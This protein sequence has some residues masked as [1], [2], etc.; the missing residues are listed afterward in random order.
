MKKVLTDLLAIVR[1]GHWS[2]ALSLLIIFG[3]GR[4]AFAG[5]P[6]SDAKASVELAIPGALRYLEKEALSW[7]AEM[8]CASCHHAPMMLWACETARAKGFPVKESAVAEIRAFI[9]DENNAA[10]LFPPADA[11]PDRDGTQIGSIYALLALNA[12][13]GGW[14]K[15]PLA[16]QTRAHFAGMQREDGSW[17]PFPSMGRPPILEQGGASAQLLVAAFAGLSADAVTPETVA[18]VEK[19]K[20]WLARPLENPSHQLEVTNYIAALATGASPEI[21][22]VRE[23]SLRAQQ[24]PD[25]SWAQSPDMAGDALATGQ[26]LYALGKAG[27]RLD[28]PAVARAVTF[29]AASQQPDGSWPMVS[30]PVVGGPAAGSLEPSENRVPIT[31]MGA[32]WAV[33]GLL[34]VL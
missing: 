15:S 13:P 24:R 20:V 4:A 34:A 29:L 25:G 23:A 33:L 7:K 6:A 8:G 18:T 28:D 27:K 19:A 3:L 32:G 16:N 17:P 21:L 11:P 31:C 2:L 30:R 22:A 14:E 5:E 1:L 10:H 26:T 9:L 12:G